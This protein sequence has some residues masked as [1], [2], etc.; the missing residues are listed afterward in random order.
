[1]SPI[2]E[3]SPKPS[4]EH[5]QSPSPPLGKDSRLSRKSNNAVAELGLSLQTGKKLINPIKIVPKDRASPSSGRD[6]RIQ[7]FKKETNSRLGS[8]EIDLVGQSSK[9]ST[10][11]KQ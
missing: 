5:S 6:T 9:L 7:V 8:I 2:R 11:L 1:M 10:R 4:K 3:P